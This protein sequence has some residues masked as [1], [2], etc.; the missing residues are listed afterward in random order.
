M[1]T[2]VSD[3]NEF[4]LPAAVKP[5]AYR[6]SLEPDLD[7]LTFR[8]EVTIE[9]EV[10]T[11]TREIVLH[12]ATL[13]VAEARLASGGALEIRP[14]AARERITLTA[15]QPLAAGPA[16]VALRFRGKLAEEM[17]GFYRSTYARP[18]GT[19]GV[20]ATTQFEAT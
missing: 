15:A 3:A 7:A 1:E 8:G 18:D 12:A 13:D 2:T 9:L 10:K 5:K 6:L 17:R 11:P 19:K 4:R 20:M 14:D 16:A